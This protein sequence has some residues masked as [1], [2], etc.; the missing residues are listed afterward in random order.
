MIELI[1]LLMLFVG[2]PLLF[3]AR[4]RIS[5]LEHRLRLVEEELRRR[6]A[7][8][9]EVL[10]EEVA[11]VFAHPAPISEPETTP[12]PV[13]E[14]E[15]R[16]EPT[17][18]PEPVEALEPEQPAPAS[19][20]ASEPAP[21][22]AMAYAMPIEPAVQSAGPEPEPQPETRFADVRSPEQLYPTRK[23]D[24]E[25][26]FGRRLPIWAGGITLAIAGVLIVKYAIDIGF[27]GRVFTPGVQAICGMLF[28]FS[29]IG[30]AEWA[31][32]QARKVDDPRVSQALSGAGISTL[33]AALLV[34]AN[35]Y[36]LISPLAAF[37]GLAAVTAGALWLS[38]RHGMPSA[39]LGLAGGLAAPALTVG[40]DADVSMLAVYL[41]FTIA[42]LVGVSRMQRWPWLAALALAGGAGWSLWLIL[43]GQA[44]TWLGALSVGTFVLL[45]AIALPLFAFTGAAATLLRMGSAVIGAAQLALL[46]ATG[47]YQPLHWGLFALIAAA[48]QWLAWRDRD[49]AIVPTLGAALS[50]LLLLLWPAPTPG[51]LALVGLSLAAIHALPLLAK[52]WHEPVRLQWAA[53]LS[54]IAVAMPIVA[55]RHFHAPWGLLDP[56][57]AWTSAGGALLVLTGAALGWKSADR[58]NDHRYLLLVSVGAGLLSVAAWFGFPAWQAPLWT[59]AIA[60]ALLLLAGPARDWRL[61]PLAGF[62]SGLALIV[63]L[64]TMDDGKGWSELQVLVG[65][66]GITTDPQSLLRW[67]GLA[68]V[69]A[70]L[71]WSGKRELTR[72]PAWFWCAGLAYG[73]AAQLVPA[74]SLPLAMAAVGG[75]ALFA[76]QRRDPPLAET[77]ILVWTAGAVLLLAVTGDEPF[78]QWQRLSGAGEHSLSALALLRW[79]GVAVFAALIAVRARNTMLRLIGAGLAT[80]LGYGAAAQVVPVIAVPLVPAAAVLG[81]AIWSRRH[82]QGPRLELAMALLVGVSALWALV[83]LA[84]WLTAA[85]WSL[86]GVPMEL[87]S[88]DLTPL[89]VLRRLLA[90]ALLLSGAV[91]ALR[92]RLSGPVLLL[93]GGALGAVWLIAVHSLYRAAFAA[94]LGT[95][96]VTYGLAQRLLWELLLLGGALALWRR[97]GLLASHAAPAAVAAAALH[98]VWYGLA[99]HNPLWSD[100][101]V[102]GWPLANLLFPLFT[103]LP[104]CL[105]LATRMREDWAPA[106]ISVLQGALMIMIGMFA[107]ATLRHAFHGSLLTAPGLPQMED[108]LRSLLGIALAVGYLLWGIRARR[109][110]W[111]IASLVLMLAAVAKV[112]LFDAS[113]LEGLLR[114]ASFVALGFSLI[115]IG[116]LY[117]R[118]L[119]AEVDHGPINRAETPEIQ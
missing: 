57:G 91:Y 113:G 52:L 13:A 9:K 88:P 30:G 108:I 28:G 48:G 96:F 25:E 82:A 62:F 51:W 44:L 29:L 49:F 81:L 69:F 100:Q 17:P 70:M 74:W 77:Q 4:S 50:V 115:G 35:V 55:L 16:P 90:P 58:E 2:F 84:E 107:W 54:G 110:S 41:T 118:Q 83:P 73:F 95:D 40:L 104:A 34:A 109:R 14:T 15:A 64:V 56:L 27:F 75:A 42:G 46:V 92:E 119:K 78:H 97:G 12:T 101:A 8:G 86:G 67:G 85:T 112:F 114:I 5:Q 33:Y 39:L 76:L 61:E 89:A 47:G 7:A 71:G 99:I 53:E 19:E 10:R 23:F 65:W 45:L 1:V 11:P 80:L 22:P 93:G 36:Q 66:S 72:Q 103:A 60:A 116:W 87:G 24:F 63:L 68:M 117:S 20:P 105:V 31:H 37:A 26:L 111:R 94:A 38:L 32:R 106:L 21:E 98:L 6:I 102:G 59:G 3:G 79:A 18:E 43:A